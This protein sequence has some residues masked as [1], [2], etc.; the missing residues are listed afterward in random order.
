MIDHV[1]CAIRWIY[2][3]IAEYGGDPNQ[4][5]IFG[6][7]AG[8]H[9]A[10]TTLMPDW[11]I[12]YELPDNVIKGAGLTSGIYDLK[13]HVLGYIP[14]QDLFQMTL[15]D[16]SRASPLFHLPTHSLPVVMAYGEKKLKAF[17]TQSKKYANCL[18][19]R[20]CPVTL[21]EV[22]KAH[23]FDMINALS[24]TQEKLFQAL[25]QAIQVS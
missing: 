10:A 18:Q 21:I 22:S 15:E 8:A 5:F 1:R 24:K 20:N 4:L 25:I 23:H 2:Q 11:P 13:D 19:K 16:A 6:N 14:P 9:L 7:S 3:N 17:I 12:R